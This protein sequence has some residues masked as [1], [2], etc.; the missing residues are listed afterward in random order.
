MIDF[1]YQDKV[2]VL[3]GLNLASSSPFDRQEWFTILADTVPKARV[4]TAINAIGAAA[5]PLVE[6]NGRLESLVNWY[7]FGWRPLFTP[8]ANRDALLV[9]LARNLKSHRNRITLWPLPD[10]DGS[11]SAVEQAFRKAGWATFRSRCDTCHI[12][13][14]N[15]RTYTDYLASRP[16]KLRTTLKRKAKKLRVDIYTHFQDDLWNIYEEIYKESWKPEESD[17]VL[18]RRFAQQEGN[19]GRIRFALA[20]SDGKP[21]AVQFWT[22]ESGRAFIHKLAHLPEAQPLSP[23]SVLTAALMERVIDVDGVE[24]IDFGTGDDPYKA[25]WM[26][27]I[28]PR[29]LIDCHD[30][31]NLR[32]WP[33]ILRGTA[34]N[35][36]SRWR[37]G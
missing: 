15:G 34:R 24:I 4:A 35:L 14:V 30:P 21:V 32:S 31:A 37:D 2:N 6:R 17:P 26:E 18:L 33:H 8:D 12:L 28:E 13:P 1:C 5:L 20:S 7:A 27:S 11:A 22:V 23:G 10:E 29:F 3:Q 9:E 19:A 16:G 25:D 36:A